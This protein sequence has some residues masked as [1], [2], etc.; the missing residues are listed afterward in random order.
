M[1]TTMKKTTIFAFLSTNSS[2]EVLTE[3]AE[4]QFMVLQSSQAL[5]WFILQNT[6]A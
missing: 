6:L 3:M 1:L 4:I 2:V 5:L